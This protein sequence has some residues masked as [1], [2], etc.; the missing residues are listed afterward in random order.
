MLLKPGM[1][2]EAEMKYEEKVNFKKAK[3]TGPYVYLKIK[4]RDRYVKQ[5]CPFNSDMEFCGDWC[6]LF[7]E[8]V[9]NKQSSV[10][11]LSLC[12][13]TLTM[14]YRKKRPNEIPLEKTCE[15]CKNQKY[16][17]DTGPCKECWNYSHWEQGGGIE[18]KLKKSN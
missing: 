13:K 2:G 10:T 7:G 3:E 5:L 6:P 18:W 11:S 16:M 12:Q 9:H 17:R 1:K 4:R 14:E 8:L 15:N